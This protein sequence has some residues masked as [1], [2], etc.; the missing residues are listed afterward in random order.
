MASLY[1]INNNLVN[2][3]NEIESNDGEVNDDLYNRLTITQDELINK[4]DD[5]VKAI[6][7][8]K[9]DVDALKAEKSALN[10]RQNV[11]KNR[12]ERLK[13]CIAVAINNFGNQGKNNKFI[14]LRD[15]RIFTKNSITAEIDVDRCNYFIKLLTDYI[16]E[17]YNNG[18]LYVGN[19]FDKVGI[20]NAI[21]NIALSEKGSDFEVFTL[22]DFNS[23]IINV[24]IPVSIDKLFSSKENVA[25]LIAKE[26]ITCEVDDDKNYYKTILEEDSIDS[27]TIAKLVNNQSIVIK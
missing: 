9:V 18:C 24:N 10:C 5:Y 17:L 26:N 7:S 6:K 16:K 4:L 1:E 3:F 21:N 11:Y 20:L 2:I 23:I 12:V 13:K 22:D 15:C 8:W 14:E 19:D 25:T 27:L